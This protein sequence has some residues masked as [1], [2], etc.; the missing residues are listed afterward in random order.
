MKKKHQNKDLKFVLEFS[1]LLERDNIN[2]TYRGLFSQNIIVDILSLTEKNIFKEHDPSKVKKKVY[3][4]MVESLQNITKH[5]IVNEELYLKQNGL[6][7]LQHKGDRYYITTANLVE[8]CQVAPLRSK[9]EMVNKLD[10]ASLK[11]EYRQQLMMGR[12]SNRGGAG[13]GFIDMARKSGNKLHCDFRKIR[14]GFSFFYFRIQISTDPS[15]PVIKDTAGKTSLCYI[16]DIH[17]GI[18]NKDIVLSYFNVFNEEKQSNFLSYLRNQLA[19][20]VFA[21]TEV[22][23]VMVEMMS[24]ISK[25]GARDRK[26]G[27]QKDAIFFIKEDSDSYQLFSGNYVENKDVEAFKNRLE[28]IND[29]SADELDTLYTQKIKTEQTEGGGMLDMRLKSVKTW[30]FDFQKTDEKYTYFALRV[31]VPKN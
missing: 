27:L 1:K 21:K 16:A 22:Y 9:I 18:I 28:E 7:V 26:T 4:L 12:I 8:D 31:G 11:K 23:N 19:K 29:L 24:N 14:E 25:H 6:F 30:D 13:L 3:N 2:Y 17:S 5:Q 10:K 15:T 20:T